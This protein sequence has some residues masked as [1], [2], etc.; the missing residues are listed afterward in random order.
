MN[1]TGKFTRESQIPCLRK[2]Q[3]VFLVD[4]EHGP[5]YIDGNGHPNTLVDDVLSWFRKYRAKH[6]ALLNAA[7]RRRSK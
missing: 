7:R 6:V 1:H 3:R 4:A 2:P 5:I